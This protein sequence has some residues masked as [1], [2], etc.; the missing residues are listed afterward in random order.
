ML[1]MSVYYSDE[2]YEILKA[3]EMF[4]DL[5]YLC[6]IRSMFDGRLPK[7]LDV[8]NKKELSIKI[9]KCRKKILDIEQYLTIH[10][11]SENSLYEDELNIAKKV[12]LFYEGLINLIDSKLIPDNFIVSKGMYLE[13]TEG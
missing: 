6:Y 11:Y 8:V 9:K 5:E 3:T 4:K 13:V 2:F 12:V 10:K 1:T 7:C